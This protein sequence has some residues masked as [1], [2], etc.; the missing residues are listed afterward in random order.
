[1]SAQVGIPV[2]YFCALFRHRHRL[3][4]RVPPASRTLLLAAST[5]PGQPRAASRRRAA[6]VDAAR[7]GLVALD[8][9]AQRKR[10]GALRFLVDE[11]APGAYLG[12]AAEALLRVGFACGACASPRRAAVAALAA[13]AA[14]AGPCRD[15]ADPH[16]DGGDAAVARAALA[17]LPLLFVGVL[18]AGDGGAAPGAAHAILALAL[19]APAAAAAAAFRRDGAAPTLL[20][21]AASPSSLCTVADRWCEKFPAMGRR[22]PS[23]ASVLSGFEVSAHDSDFDYV[24]T[25]RVVDRAISSADSSP[26]APRR[27]PAPPPDDGGGDEPPG[28]LLA[29]TPVA[30]FLDRQLADGGGAFFDAGDA[31]SLDSLDHAT[32]IVPPSSPSAAS[33]ES[34]TLFVA[35]SPTSSSPATLRASPA[36]LAD[37]EPIRPPSPPRVYDDGDDDDDAPFAGCGASPTSLLRCASPPI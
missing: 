30:S 34:P 32:F 15:A 9:L 11:Y 20:E 16:Y 23:D 14:V 27:E 36:D 19:A 37:P 1:M 25:R 12:P 2:A 18:A 33:P 4:P 26:A 21:Q 8:V 7:D 10:A 24:Q 6:V 22:A 17:A 29:P 5:P 3:N 31:D 13:L 35:C 28:L